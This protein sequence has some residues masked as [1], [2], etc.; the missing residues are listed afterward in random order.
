LCG[1]L[2]LPPLF[3]RFSM[4]QV[5]PTERFFEDYTAGETHEFGSYTMTETE[6]IAFARQWD[7]QSFHTDPEAA[8]G[9]NYGGLIASGWHTTCVMMRLLVENW[10]SPRASMGSPGVD[11]IRWHRPVRPGDTLRVRITVERVRRSESKPDRGVVFQKNEVLNQADEVVMS[12]R[13]MGMYRC[14]DTAPP[15]GG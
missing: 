15:S 13:G 6:I 7:P 10:I 5:P 12:S 8:Q 1:L 2:S 9:S 4:S 3:Q 11:E 14:R